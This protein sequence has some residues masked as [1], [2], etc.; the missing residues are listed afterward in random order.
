M[1]RIEK[2]NYNYI[3]LSQNPV[4]LEEKEVRQTQNKIVNNNGCLVHGPLLVHNVTIYILQLNHRLAS[5][6][7][8]SRSLV[9][10]NQ[11]SRRE[12]QVG[13]F[14]TCVNY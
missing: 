14:D 10:K 2:E 9:Q 11:D 7:T 1:S 4:N 12:Q 8:S 6:D 5:E 3:E 13:S